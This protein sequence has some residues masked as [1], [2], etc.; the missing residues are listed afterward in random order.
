M[1]VASYKEDL[2]PVTLAISPLE[3]KRGDHIFVDRVLGLYQEHA[4]YWGKNE[5]GEQMVIRFTNTSKGF[6]KPTG[7]IMK[8]T[9]E[10][11]LKGANPR[12]VIYDTMS[13][14]SNLQ[15]YT[16][17]PSSQPSSEVIKTAEY[18]L[19]HPGEWEDYKRFTNNCKTFCVYCKTRKQELDSCHSYQG[20]NKW[21]YLYNIIVLLCRANFIT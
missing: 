11:Y 14:E 12:I 6:T 4:I 10:H 16:A 2:I 18:Y 7:E 19:E 3:L 8:T 21:N 5:V 15:L 13:D 20:I 9:L 1:A 17:A